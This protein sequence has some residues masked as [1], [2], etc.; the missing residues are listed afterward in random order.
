MSLVDWKMVDINS[1]NQRKEKQCVRRTFY[2]EI[3]NFNGNILHLY[4]FLAYIP[5]Q[6]S[7]L[8]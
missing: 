1:I 4:E 3:S 7:F 5:L 2:I 6:Y 8:I